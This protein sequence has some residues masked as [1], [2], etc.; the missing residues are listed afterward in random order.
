METTKATRETSKASME[1]IIK[2]GRAI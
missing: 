1:K 2:P